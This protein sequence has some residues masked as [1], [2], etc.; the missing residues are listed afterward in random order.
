MIAKE[1]LLSHLARGAYSHA[2][3]LVGGGVVE[4]EA[5]ATAFAK[6]LAISQFDWHRLDH[7]A[8]T[9]PIGAVREL[10]RRL[11]VKPGS[12]SHHLVLIT[13]SE[14]LTVE[15]QNALLKILEEPPSPTVFLLSAASERQLLATVVSRCQKVQLSAEQ[16]G[17]AS[18]IS[19]V[20]LADIVSQPLDAQFAQAETLAKSEDLPAILDEWALALRPR[21]RAG[22]REAARLIELL[23]SAKE[24]MC[25]TQASRRLILE[26]V[27][28]EATHGR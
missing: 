23:L 15:A 5:I 14:A 6:K 21:M 28:V 19:P 1:T 27:F 9:I 12:S 10:R 7:T 18:G 22:D 13:G 20:S 2:Y 11:A 25:E 26:H 8:G 16:S 24:K 4:A 17:E 3:L